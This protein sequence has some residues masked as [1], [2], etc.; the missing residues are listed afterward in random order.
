VTEA[1]YNR[2]LIQGQAGKNAAARQTFYQVVDRAPSHELAPLAYYQI[3]RLHLE[4][5]EPDQAL[6]PLR[7]S[8]ASCNPATRAVVAQ[9]T[10]AAYLLANNPRAA[11]RT[12]V[13]HRLALVQPDHFAATAFLDTLARYRMCTDEK[14]KRLERNDLLACVL[15][16]RE[17]PTL[18]P[19]GGL[20][21][22]QAHQEVGLHDLLIQFATKALPGL[23]GPVSVEMNAILADTYYAKG[24]RVQAEK[25]YAGLESDSGRHSTAARLRLAEIAHQEGKPKDCLRWCKKALEKAEPGTRKAALRLMATSYESTG[26]RDKA[27][28]CLTGTPP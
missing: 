20:L 21:L 17:K 26:E 9:T 24:K 16:S 4:D 7:R 13:E 2:G 23:R 1:H 15:T 18:G 5:H 27:I 28:L 6:S 19:P 25:L 11:N 12:L 14:K 3:G 22:A 10:A 8:L